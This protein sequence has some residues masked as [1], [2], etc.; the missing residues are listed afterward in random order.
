[1]AGVGN[2]GLKQTRFQEQVWIM[3]E[4]VLWLLCVWLSSVGKFDQSVLIRIVRLCNG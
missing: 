2:K 4:V 3:V 1:M